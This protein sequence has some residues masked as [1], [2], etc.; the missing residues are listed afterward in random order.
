MLLSAASS[1]MKLMAFAL[2]CFSVATITTAKPFM[3][4]HDG[5]ITLGVPSSTYDAVGKATHMGKITETG[6]FQFAA[7]SP[8]LEAELFVTGDATMIGA[9][10]DSVSF[11][12]EECAL[13]ST[14]GFISI[15]NYTFTGGT[16]RFTGATGIGTFTTEGILQEP[17]GPKYDIHTD[18]LGTIDY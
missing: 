12:V 10:G 17:D 7:P 3:A 18:Y 4:S 11:T 2:A 9:N 13:L 1:S 15:G 5:I 8:C 6:S 16:G 14:D